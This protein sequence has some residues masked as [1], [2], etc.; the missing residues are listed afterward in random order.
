MMVRTIFNL[1]GPLTNPAG[2]ERQLLGVYDAAWVVPLAN[3]LKELGSKHVM[4]VHSEDGLDE[5]SI[6]ATTRVAEL[7]NGVI[8]EYEIAPEHFG[9]ERSDLDGLKVSDSKESLVLVRASL[10][11]SHKG[12]SDIV[13]LNAGAAI[14]VSGTVDNLKSGVDMAS[15]AISSGRAADKM[16]EF[17][18]FT[19]QLTEAG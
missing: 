3:V 13:A 12:A 9:L 18:D 4:V 17:V 8:T 2:A 1:L 10:D 5:V 6:S 11:G 7:N 19:T 16:K 15:E 14:Y